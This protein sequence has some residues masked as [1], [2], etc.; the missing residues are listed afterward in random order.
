MDAKYTHVVHTSSDAYGVHEYRVQD[1]VYD[2]SP[3]EPVRTF[4][5]HPIDKHVND[6]RNEQRRIEALLDTS[7]VT[8]EMN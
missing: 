4:V 6:A 1:V 8:N 3:G 5:W 7:N 2:G